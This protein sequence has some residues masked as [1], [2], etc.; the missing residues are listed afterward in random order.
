MD[1]LDEQL[2]DY[3]ERKRPRVRSIDALE[4]RA[5]R[6][7]H[8]GVALQLAAAGIVV[9]VLAVPVSRALEDAPSATSDGPRFAAGG[10]QTVA[11]TPS[12]D[13][14]PGTQCH[15]GSEKLESA[16]QWLGSVLD[17]AKLTYRS[18]YRSDGGGGH[19]VPPGQ[20]LV[21]ALRP[22]EDAPVAEA[23]KYGHKPLATHGSTVVYGS[24]ESDIWYFYWRAGGVDMFAETAWP[25]SRRESLP[26]LEALFGRIIDAANDEPYPYEGGA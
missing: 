10:A 20:F 1:R 15:G 4:R 25:P 23:A 9:A 2:K 21:A 12:D 13:C 5:V 8:R 11:P 17:A 16:E 18:S 3:A 7:R 26:K 24:I 6:R 19:F 22:S 14:G